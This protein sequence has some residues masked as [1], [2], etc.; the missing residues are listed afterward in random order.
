M[1]YILFVSFRIVQIYV[2][3]FNLTGNQSIVLPRTRTR[4][5]DKYKSRLWKLKKLLFRMHHFSDITWFIFNHMRHWMQSPSPN[6]LLVLCVCW[7]VCTISL[8][9]YVCCKLQLCEFQFVDVKVCG[10][11]VDINAYNPRFICVNIYA[12]SHT[13]THKAGLQFQTFSSSFTFCTRSS[14]LC[15]CECVYPI[16]F[17][18]THVVLQ[19]HPKI[20]SI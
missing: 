8:W 15:V 4:T 18:L 19:M 2:F 16:W 10:L 3:F 13:H 5:N 14:E 6:K 9:M 17:H 11:S 1:K 20:H 12:H 7:C